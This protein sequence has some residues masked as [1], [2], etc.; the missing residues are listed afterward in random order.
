MI[1]ASENINDM[2]YLR[3]KD[4]QEV[5]FL[6]AEN[7]RP[8]LLVETKLSDDVPAANLLAFQDILK[9]PAVQLVKKEGV[10]KVYK[11]GK[12][13]VLVVTAHRWLS[14]LP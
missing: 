2:H 4:K 5:D 13:N 12:N 7:N 3:N 1:D 10:K 11:N 6:I 14:T 8:M 9:I